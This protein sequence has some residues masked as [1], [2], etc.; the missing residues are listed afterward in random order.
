MFP[1]HDVIM[2]VQGLNANHMVKFTYTSL[3]AEKADEHLILEN[4]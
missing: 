4:I 2:S 1:F 3:V